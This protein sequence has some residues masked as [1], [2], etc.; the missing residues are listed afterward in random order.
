MA[1]VLAA[2][3]AVPLLLIAVLTRWGVLIA[4]G[5]A[6]VVGL[7]IW[8]WQKGFVFVE[9]VAFLIH[10]DGLGAGP[11]TVGR[12]M[13]GIAALILIT[14]FITGWKPPTIPVRHWGPLW[15]LSIWAL[16]TGFWSLD[17][18]ALFYAFGMYGLGMAYFCITGLLIDSH[19]I[20][21][22]F[23][24]A[25][26]VG[27][28][29]GS[30]AGILALFLG[31][32]SVGFGSDPNFFGLLQASMIPLTVYYRRHAVTR[33]EVWFYSITLVVVLGGAAGAGS[34]SGLI[35]G[36]VAI[37]GT[38]VTRP[39]LRAGRRVVVGAG[40]VVLAG[41][42]FLVG[43]VANPNN[44]ERG[45][46]DRGA[47]RLD[48]WTVVTALVKE[49]PVLG[50]GFGQLKTIIPSNLLL[51]PGSQKLNELRP[52]V[53]AHNT[54]LDILGDL[55]A[56]GLLIF[57]SVFVIAILGFARPRWTQTRELS[58]T[59][60]VMMLPVLSGSFF[61]PLLNNKLAW[62][63]IGLSASLAVPS[64]Q[65]R[66]SGLARA[67]RSH[68]PPAAATLP[69]VRST[70]LDAA[71]VVRAVG[72]R[73]E[74]P[75]E[76]VWEPVQL[77]RWDLRIPRRQQVVV[78]LAGV[79]VAFVAFSVGS[80]V[81][82]TYTASAGVIVPRVD[83][84]T[85]TENIRFDQERLQSA[86]TLGVSGA[87][88]Q[89]LIDR[90]GLDLSVDEVRDRLDATRPRMGLYVEIAYTDTDRANVEAVMPHL[91]DSLDQVFSGVQELA[92]DDTEQ[93]LRPLIPG[94]SR[95]YSGPAYLH[96]FSEPGFAITQPRAAWYGLVGFLVGAMTVLGW[97]LTGQRR[98]RIANS[99]DLFRQV[100]LPVWAHV[101]GSRRRRATRDQYAQVV[102][103]AQSVLASDDPVHRIVVASPQRQPLAR[104]L[105]LGVAAEL[106]A[107]GVR[108]VLVDA[109]LDRPLL[110]AR[111]GGFGRPG[112]SDV[113]RGAALVDVVRRVR[114][115]RLPKVER[116]VLGRAGDNLRVVP[117]GRR[118]GEDRGFALDQLD[119]LD[120]DVA[121]VVL[122][123][124]T[125]GDR[126]VSALLSWADTLVMAATVG[127]TS[128]HDLED[129][130]AQVDSF[131]VAPA[132]VVM[133][134]G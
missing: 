29:F 54:W 94:E 49:S 69:A 59:L 30:A 75:G 17:S 96:A 98:P 3:L 114:R 10:F 22:Q 13:A 116:R 8:V 42:A 78:V 12:V 50:Y 70:D 107:Q 124:P 4:I 109:D 37:V 102:A 131:S 1:W 23:L 108:T 117:A 76:E 71:P 27:G 34:R 2:A 133:L 63:L 33:G 39:G 85:G 129:A 19:R 48:V 77:A 115:W 16:I 112:L 100:A 97:L 41:F 132:G 46:A 5:V 120:R 35:G 119:Q 11:L 90:A 44:L 134:D 6:V 32:R 52:E 79:I 126:P 15:A 84:S 95:V 45:F 64:V 74:A 57:V 56:I 87:Y 83:G 7:G 122:A 31:T 121:I 72:E 103:T 62:A 66:W 53:Y 89:E 123:P 51:T 18:G 93:G 128:T 20:V 61:L 28:L 127:Q 130:A 43:F 14:K 92:G 55:G 91:I 58:T 36:A 9:I 104:R 118:R 106:A 40:A 25:Y 110:S 24:R 99:D 65:A 60:F 47:G 68:G 67:V 101:G 80:I 125:L 73:P 105:A 38:M 21:Q 26:W 111:L 86:L 82:T 113:A 88:A 81:P